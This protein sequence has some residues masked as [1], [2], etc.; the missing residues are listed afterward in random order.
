FVNN[1]LAAWEYASKAKDIFSKH[2]GYE[3]KVAGCHNVIGIVGLQLEQFENAEMQF[4]I[5][6]NI[7]QKRNIQEEENYIIRTKY[8]LGVMYADQDLSEL[9]I[10][11]LSEVRE[12]LPNHFRAIFLEAREYFKLGKTK[13]AKD[14]IEDGL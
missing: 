7:L 6:M 11:H 9:A 12:K 5:A 1:L 8:N 4:N 10:R 13:I 3:F 14:L 2:S